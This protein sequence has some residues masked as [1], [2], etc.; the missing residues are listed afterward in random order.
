I[1]R[2]ARDGIEV[3]H[4]LASYHRGQ[5]VSSSGNTHA[6]DLALFSTPTW[7]SKIMGN[8]P[9]PVTNAPA[10]DDQPPGAVLEGSTV[11]IPDERNGLVFVFRVFEKMS[12]A[13]VMKATKPLYVGDVV[14]TP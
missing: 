2:G 1:N 5:V 13:M 7:L 4:V 10:T 6:S 14:Q 11:Q 9:P 8:T 3:G 12:Y